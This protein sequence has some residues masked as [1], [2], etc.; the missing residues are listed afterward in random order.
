MKWKSP[1]EVV[2]KINSDG[3]FMSQCQISGLA[4]EMI[5]VIALSKF[6]L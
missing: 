2:I 6:L 1:G 4:F 5:K 3:A